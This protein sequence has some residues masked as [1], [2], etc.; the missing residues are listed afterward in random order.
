[1][2]AWSWT[3][4]PPD[5]PGYWQFAGVFGAF[6]KLFNYFYLL[7]SYLINQLINNLPTK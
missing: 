1:M 5:A 4:A 7:F 2:Y 6:E 3:R